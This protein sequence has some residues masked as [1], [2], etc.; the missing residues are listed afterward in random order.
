MFDF[1]IQMKRA[2]AT[3]FYSKRTR[4]NVQPA[5]GVL[6][7][8]NGYGINF[9]IDESFALRLFDSA[10]PAELRF[11]PWRFLPPIDTPFGFV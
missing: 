9:F 1:A 8:P 6:G 10:A 7:S 4:D 3:H 5:F 2:V 11:R